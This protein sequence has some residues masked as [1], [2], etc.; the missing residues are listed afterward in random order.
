MD[1]DIP[2][3]LS[4]ETIQEAEAGIERGMNYCDECE[5]ETLDNIDDACIKH[6][7]MYARLNP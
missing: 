6:K 3:D 1:I 7:K 4:E 5:A 2:E